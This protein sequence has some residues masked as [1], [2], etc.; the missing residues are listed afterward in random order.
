[1]FSVKA[2]AV[3]ED[4]TQ[5][6]PEKCFQEEKGVFIFR[7]KVPLRLLMGNKEEYAFPFIVLPK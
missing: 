6:H 5:S 2:V 1:M 3:A 7:E 4:S